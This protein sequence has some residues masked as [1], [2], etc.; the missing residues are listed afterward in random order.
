MMAIPKL[1][2][3]AFSTPESAGSGDATV[4]IHY[5][6]WCPIRTAHYKCH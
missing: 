4:K 1:R 3:V 2:D 5:W 6:D